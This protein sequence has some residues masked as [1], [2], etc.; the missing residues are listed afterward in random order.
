MYVGILTGPFS[1]EPLEVVAAFAGQ[2]RFGGLELATGP[3]S[4]HID[5]NTFDAKAADDVMN[6]MIK[7]NLQISGLAAYTNVT[8]GDPERRKKNIETVHNA[9]TAASLLGIDVV[10]CMA[11]MPVPGK[12]RFKTI[13]EDCKEVFPPLIE[14]AAE[15]KVK[16][17]MENWTATNIQNLAH[18]ERIFEVL[19]YENFGLNFDPSHLHW[20]DIDYIEAVDR[21]G[22][23]IFHSHGKDTEIKTHRKRIVGNQGSGWWRYVIP[24]LGQIQWGQYIAAL[25]RNGYN[26]VISIEHE[27]DAVEREEGFLIGKKYLEQFIVY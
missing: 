25:R 10:C 26:G 18:W 1:G 17:A 5:T 14:Y 20:Q 8:D 4:K 15:K 9:I 16:L 13:E 7:R 21:F 23:R 11:G 3:G 6:L 27:D 22:K 19:P 24:G 2:Y 12:D